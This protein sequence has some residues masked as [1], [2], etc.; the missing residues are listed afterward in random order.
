MRMN[1]IIGALLIAGGTITL[2]YQM[3]RPGPEE[4]AFDLTVPESAREKRQ[5]RRLALGLG[6]ASLV[7]GLYVMSQ[8]RRRRGNDRH[9]ARG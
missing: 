5:D 1:V 6:S 8:G 2:V 3:S 7:A 4:A 9:G